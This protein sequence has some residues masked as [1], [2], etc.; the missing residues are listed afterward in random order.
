M[1]NP[2]GV[3][4][5]ELLVSRRAR[6]RYGLTEDLFATE[7]SVIVADFKTA[8]Q[9]AAAINRIRRARGDREISAS[10]LFAAGLLHEFM[11]VLIGRFL[12]TVDSEAFTDALEEAQIDIGVEA[13]DRTL[14]AFVGAFPPRAVRSGDMTP[15]D[16][17]EGR[18]GGLL[19]RRIVLEEMLLL[20]LAETNPALEEFGD[21]FDDTTLRRQTT[22][23]LLMDRLEAFLGKR[24]G[25]ERSGP[26]LIELLRAPI[27]ASP[28]SLRG[29]LEFI[30]EHWGTWVKPLI[31]RLLGGLDFL[32][33]E[34]R[35]VFPP[36][37]GPVQAPSFDS[38][39]DDAF[40]AFSP[41]RDWMPEVVLLAKNTPVWL[42]QL[43][44]EFKRPVTRLN[45]VPDEELDRLAARGITGLW[46]IGIWERS[47]ASE[48]IKRWMGDSD[49]VA[50]AYSLYDYVV[51][52]N[53]GGRSAFEDL[54]ARAAARGIRLATDMVPNHVGIDGRWVIEH[55]DWFIG[56]SECPFPGYRF[57]GADLSDDERVGIFIEDGYWDRSDAAVVFKRV[58]RWTGDVR[59]IYHGNDGTSMPWNDTAQLDYRKAEVREAVI[60]TILHVADLSPI[61]R[62]DAAMTL[63]RRNFQ[64]LWF[65]EPGTGGDIPSRA[66][67]GMDRETFDRMMPREFWR[68]VVD[69]VAD[70][71]PDTLLL[72]EA[73]WM[74][75][76]FFVRTLGMHRV[77]N[78][79]F[80][81]MLRDEA[82]DEYR[83]LIRKTL[84]YDPRILARYVN[85]MSNP[86]EE[87]AD[88]QFGRGD[89]YFG[90]CTLM[91]TMPGLP[92]FG[93][94]QI[95]GYREKYGMEFSR[96]RW[97]EN[98]DEGLITRHERQIFPLLRKRRLFAG[99]E[100]FRLYDLV[101]DDRSVDEN[102]FAYSNEFDGRRSL[103]VYHNRFAETAGWIDRAVPR[104]EPGVEGESRLTNTD[105]GS[106]LG[107]SD[108]E[109]HFIV[110]RD[111]VSGLEFIRSAR[112]IDDRGLFVRL[113]AY[114]LHVFWQFRDVFDDAEGSWGRLCGHLGGR[115][116]DT[117][118]LV[119]R[120]L[121]LEPVL[122]P[123]RK[124]VEALI[125]GDSQ[126]DFETTLLE[127]YVKTARFYGLR[128]E[129][130]ATVIEA[131]ERIRNAPIDEG[132]SPVEPWRRVAI[133][134]AS[135]AAALHRALDDQGVATG[136]THWLAGRVLR[137]VAVES[138]WTPE[139][140]ERCALAAGLLTALDTAPAAADPD[141]TPSRRFERLLDE[142]IV[143]D[144]LGVNRWQGRTWVRKERLEEALPWFEVAA[145]WWILQ[146][147]DPVRFDME[148]FPIELKTA[149]ERAGYEVEPMLE[150]LAANR[151]EDEQ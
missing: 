43:A 5:F 33:E 128:F 147:E 2:I 28:R 126:E 45:E 137:Q 100:H 62:F 113:H 61:I 132:E 120:E 140:A 87:T 139:D 29:Q 11:H 150:E 75:E 70:E 125:A 151:P 39:E 21:L 135:A 97:D 149:A 44:H 73:F 108:R 6:V 32:A 142:E 76:G 93:H 68:D 133:G 37:P 15:P 53:L 67:F 106:A 40:E 31:D 18:T 60:R 51:A 107:A 22:Y 86:D 102:V 80:M 88:E 99:V 101:R 145:R 127:F 79:A 42:D 26:N 98:P 131:L 94:G 83:L 95:E 64:R 129:A 49:A 122:S 148:R 116:V 91:A 104:V 143:A 7:A 146:T 8:R 110:F 1:K 34:H 4:M 41:D 90:I 117:V 3:A 96:P 50:S 89:K 47:R 25:L 144:S 124:V 118:D 105:V 46:L 56:L 30:R 77:Y 92:M 119:R 81:N 20:R 103:V 9:A 54:K 82:N 23:P 48:K 136:W 72:A 10:D 84:E 74:L 69:R 65:P 71:R 111:L 35:P 17:L 78:S 57:T 112:E 55:P 85:F 24:P 109:D 115:G 130:A 123:W 58:D 52:E 16:Y 63:T 27:E 19:N 114:E 141:E 12:E 13:V 14:E 134:A 36:G 38:P 138:G 66:A 121:E 59:Y